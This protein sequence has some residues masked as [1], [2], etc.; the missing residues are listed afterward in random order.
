MTRE[1]SDKML[2]SYVKLVLRTGMY[3]SLALLLIGSAMYLALGGEVGS[4][5]GPV[6][7]IRSAMDMEAIGW[8]SLGIIF[9]ILTPLAGV[10]AALLVFLKA[11]ELRM[12]GVSL[13]VLGVVAMAILVKLVA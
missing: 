11:K 3:L 9:L 12:A 10:I 6:E 4:V 13:L 2:A 5:L 8:L 1:A 7:A